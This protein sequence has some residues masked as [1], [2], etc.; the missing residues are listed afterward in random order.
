VPCQ[1]TP[2]LLFAGLMPITDPAYFDDVN[3]YAK[4]PNKPIPPIPPRPVAE[5]PF[6]GV[7]QLYGCVNVPNA[8]FYRVLVSFNGGPFNAITGLQW[9]IYPLP[10]GPPH[11]VVPDAIGWYPVLPNPTDFHPANLVLE[12][13]TPTL[14]KYSLKI[15]TGTATKTHLGFGNTVAIQVDNTAPTVLFSKLSWKFSNEPDTA[16]DLPSRNLLVPCP[17]VRRGIPARD[18]EIQ[19]ETLVSAHHLRDASL[20]THGCGGGAFSLISAP[21]N[22][23]HWHQTVSDNSVALSGRYRLDASALEGAYGFTCQANSRAMNPAGSDNGHLLDWNY[24]PIYSYVVPQ[25]EVAIVNG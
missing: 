15:E 9:N 19:F 11:P 8:A 5:T 4:R 18:I 22:T 21:V 2:E 25:V 17:T 20:T 24:D 3:G 14:G 6:L 12:W 23:A 1:N 16:L 10:I 13:P 7:L